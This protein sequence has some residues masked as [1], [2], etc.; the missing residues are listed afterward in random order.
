M[1]PD[2]RTTGFDPGPIATGWIEAL[3]QKDGFLEMCAMDRRD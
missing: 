1:L 2:R 3:G